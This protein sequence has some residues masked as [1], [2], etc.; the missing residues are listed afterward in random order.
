M[1]RLFTLILIAG[2]SMN[3]WAQKEVGTFTLYPRIGGVFS[4]FTGTEIYTQDNR[5]MDSKFKTALTAGVDLW[6]QSHR[7]VAL[8]AGLHY[9]NQGTKYDTV[10]Y[11][12]ENKSNNH[13]V[14]EY[15]DLSYNTHLLNIP[16][17]AHVFLADGL[18]VEAGLQAGILLNARCK[19]A[20]K[21]D[22]SYPAE[23]ITDQ[24]SHPT[25]AH[26]VSST[27]TEATVTSQFNT[28]SLSIPAG[29]SY[30]YEN[31][32]I[33]LRYNF[34]LTKTGGILDGHNSTIMFTIAYGFDL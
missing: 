25:L 20:F 16:L 6:W 30:E 4:M 1:K 15:Y 24:G 23:A 11:T 5:K 19:E 33:D 2:T 27:T 26:D 9:A 34:N 12:E 32:Q 17:L 13:T 18:S 7:E 29:I 22:E 8:S 31:V 10:E 28:F 14:R 3:M 21:T